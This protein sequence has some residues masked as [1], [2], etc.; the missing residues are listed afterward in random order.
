MSTFYV[1]YTGT[2]EWVPMEADSI[3]ELAATLKAE[4]K[5]GTVRKTV[6]EGEQM[7]NTKT[8]A[9]NSALIKL[10]KLS[11][12]DV[13]WITSKLEEKVLPFLEADVSNYAK[14][15]Q[16]V[17]L[18][19]EAP[20][21]NQPFKPG[22]LDGEIWQWIVDLCAKHGFKAQVALI[23][24][25][26]NI[27]PHR[28]T[29]Y[30]QPWAMGINLGKCDWHIASERNSARPDY[31]MNL[32]GGEVFKFNSKHT[33]A[34]T[35]A[36]PERWSINVWAISDGPAAESANIAGRLNNMLRD[37]PQVVE[38]I[39]KHKPGAISNKKEK[40]ENLV[41]KEKVVEMTK[42]ENGVLLN[43]EQYAAYDAIVNGDGNILMTG[44]AGTGK[45]FVL[46]E[47]VKALRAADKLPLVMATTGIAATHI[48][49][50]T[51]HS[52]L[53]MYP[54]IPAKDV[55]SIIMNGIGGAA[56]LEAVDVC[57]IDEVSMMHK[58]EIERL[59]AAMRMVFDSD[60]PFGGKR[61]VF[62]GDF[63]QI[64]PVDKTSRRE[65][66]FA[67][68]SSVWKE[69][70][71]V[72]HQLKRIV[73][74][75]D[76]YF[77]GFLNNVRQGIWTP[78]MQDIV[79]Y[80]MK[81]EK[82]ESGVVYLVAKN[83]EAAKINDTRLAELDG[84]EFVYQAVDKV[85]KKYNFSS[86]EWAPDWGYW[87]RNTLALKSLKLKVGAQVV[88]LLNHADMSGL[89]GLVN[90][91]QGIVVAL[92]SKTVTVDF[93]RVGRVVIKAE[94]FHEGNEWE[95]RS[96]IP[97]R[98]AWALTMHKSQGMTLDAACISGAN[99]FT[100]GQ[101]YVALS[102]VKTL[103][104]LYLDSFNPDKILAAKEALDFYGLPGNL[105]GAEA[106]KHSNMVDPDDGN[107]IP[108]ID[109]TPQKPSGGET[110]EEVVM[111]EVLNEKEK[112]T[113]VENSNVEYSSASNTIQEYFVKY[114]SLVPCPE[115]G[116]HKAVYGRVITNDP[117]YLK[118][119]K[120]IEVIDRGS[121]QYK[122]LEQMFGDKSFC[123]N[124]TPHATPTAAYEHGGMPGRQVV[125]STNPVKH[126]DIVFGWSD[127]DSEIMFRLRGVQTKS[128]LSMRQFG[129]VV[130]NS[131]K[132]VKRLVELIK[133]VRGA[134]VNDGEKR[135]RIKIVTHAEIAKAFPHLTDEALKVVADGINFTAVEVV[136]LAYILNNKMSKRSKKK[137]LNDIDKGKITNHTIRIL[138]NVGEVAGLIK[139][140]TLTNKRAA[141]NA[142]MREL[143]IIGE[144]EVYDV[145]VCEDN[146]KTEL[147]TDGSFEILTVEPHHGPGMVKTNDQ[148]LAQYSDVRGIFDYK[149][150]LRA[151][152]AVMDKAYNDLV[153]GRDL[154]MFENMGYDRAVTESDKLTAL[155]ADKNASDINRMVGALNDLGL[156]LGVS[157]TLM[158][159]RA[160]A[161]KK[162]FL[163]NL[164][165]GQNWAA[166]SG[167]KRSFLFMP[168]AY[169]AYIMSKEAVYMAGYDVDLTNMEGEYH[170]P[171]QTFMIPGNLCAE[172][173]GKLGGGDFDDEVGIHVRKMIMK[174][175][176]VRLVA[177]LVRTPNDWA[178][179][180]IIDI[181]EFGPVFLA[182]DDDIDMPVIYEEDFDKFKLVSA[183]GQLPSKVN[184]SGRPAKAVWDWDLT[185]Y[186]TVASEHKAAGVG[187]QVKTKMIW[188]SVNNRP[189][190][191]LPC[192]NEDMIDALQQ[193]K[194]DIQDLTTLDSWSNAAMAHMLDKRTSSGDIDAYW[195]HSRNL[196]G[197]AIM[198]DKKGL[199]SKSAVR[200][201]M[202]PKKSPIVTDLMVPRE[203]MVRETFKKMLDYLN[204]NVMVIDELRGIVP[205]SEETRFRKTVTDLEKMFQDK[206]DG[207][208]I[209]DH[210][211]E[212]A[213]KILPKMLEYKA[214]V[215]DDA[216]N[217]YLL[218]IVYMSWFRHHEHVVIRK[219]NQIKNFDR[220]LY[221]AVK[222]SDLIM[223]D[224]FYDAM[225]W[226]RNKNG[227]K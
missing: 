194:G 63:L 205:K 213:A 218:K 123:V 166:P 76:A 58:D 100:A 84:P 192:A 175:G 161:I 17:W 164:P 55:A 124:I 182:E 9:P 2:Q 116:T 212:V 215:G 197:T 92:S 136:K 54:N 134:I 133:P 107:E 72:T 87:D 97:L 68:M 150:L 35:N 79:D 115:D 162:M 28:D 23:S 81:R 66:H 221:T 132:M 142:R 86:G 95:Y 225:I 198:L 204:K 165:E 19:Y 156:P 33:H 73:R 70:G 126:P 135:L 219:F 217:L 45:S 40:K 53:R 121:Y 129:L 170:E 189:F 190:K 176:S 118:D 25:G 180:Y 22:L 167:L 112:E 96:Q 184:G 159:A 14:G 216:F 41:N 160:N 208:K 27:K 65:S 202:D 20:L 50:R 174:D 193:C 52:A 77:A 69:A 67:F 6:P 24:K 12:E 71:I 111:E 4:G 210:Y 46:N 206:P 172:I 178:E 102:R 226:W 82:P 60:K 138:T 90:G 113:V 48:G 223:T 209:G 179:Y 30:A 158:F 42:L 139:G 207:V 108:V 224:L 131:D 183:A 110:T 32:N 94:K 137:L 15:R 143:G 80:A 122:L 99:V 211:R 78:D 56:W 64:E 130:G 85:P 152:Q 155:L 31:T 120:V 196:D 144:G 104:G 39:E 127:F 191:T 47:A 10:E 29:T 51:Y 187:G 201:Q 37:N 140:N 195:Y 34:V 177:F 227:G 128:Y 59:D 157:Q 36:A 38:F 43:P 220:W 3:R 13:A 199:L 16:R 1:R 214:K 26:G 119:C 153:E 173:M 93:V 61:F 171:T 75:Q 151:F 149:E 146:F 147:G 11:S 109:Y 7:M 103:E 101:G 148:M 188:Y 74:Q 222:D 125:A 88:C 83:D 89:I 18:P 169:R 105:R 98:L 141:I 200:S 49:G 181:S 44:N 57:I 185:V 21:G 203:R 145:F 91:D 117:E 154:T 186:N 163:S 114:S 5:A 62:V 106:E 8:P 168:W